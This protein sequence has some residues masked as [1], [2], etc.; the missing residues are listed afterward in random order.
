MNY[1][2]Q[3][4]EYMQEVKDYLGQVNSGRRVAGNDPTAHRFSQTAE[5]QRQAKALGVPYQTPPWGTA[6]YSPQL[7][8][9]Y[10][11]PGNYGLRVDGTP[12]GNGYLGALP[13]TDG[14]GRVMTEYSQSNQIGGHERLYPTITPNQTPEGIASL[15]AGS[16]GTPDIDQRAAAFATLRLHQ[17]LPL[18]AVP[19]E[20][21]PV[22]TLGTPDTRQSPQYGF[23]PQQPHVQHMRDGAREAQEDLRKMNEAWANIVKRREEQGA[24]VK[25]YPDG[26]GYY[27][28]QAT[29]KM[30]KEVASIVEKSNT[31]YPSFAPK[32]PQFIDKAL[33][34]MG[35]TVSEGSRKGEVYVA[36][37]GHQLPRV[38]NTMA[39]E[40]Y[41]Q[42]VLTNG[43]PYEHKPSWGS[44]GPAGLEDRVL[45]LQPR[46]KSEPYWGGHAT[47]SV[48]ELLANIKGYEG[49][50]PKGTALGDTP[51]GQAL[52]SPSRGW[53]DSSAQ[54]RKDYYY[55]NISYPHG[56][57]WEGQQDKNIPSRAEQYKENVVNYLTKGW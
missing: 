15:L 10:G 23:T 34:S 29:K 7:S 30:P 9:Q 36:Y 38:A 17:G 25:E 21:R 6:P 42:G 37:G 4:A 20:E 24:L 16:R 5:D 40:G 26:V 19:G 52:F 11:F 22:S 28:G 53:G 12:K 41:H 46:E 18:F 31:S 49:G 33:T 3:Y 27:M 55:N 39:H 48:N 51:V 8:P 35:F 43:A 57:L 1:D 50:L 56:G 14:S 47:S 44:R 13:M 2:Q 54:E 32:D 45:E